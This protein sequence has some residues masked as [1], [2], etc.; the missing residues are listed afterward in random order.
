MACGD[1][2]GIPQDHFVWRTASIDDIVET[3][4]QKWVANFDFSPDVSVYWKEHVTSHG[5]TH[6]DVVDLA[7]KRNF[8]FE[9]RASNIREIVPHDTPLYLVYTPTPGSAPRCAHSSILLMGLKV[10][11]LSGENRT[12]QDSLRR[13]ARDRLRDAFEFVAE[14]PVLADSDS[15]NQEI[16]FE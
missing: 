3:D 6:T 16:N 5:M 13:L 8:V 14:C 10:K 9:A 1:P 4:G 7:P 2:A 11:N 12:R 15:E